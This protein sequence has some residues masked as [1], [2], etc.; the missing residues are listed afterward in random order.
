MFDYSVQN[1]SDMLLGYLDGKKRRM[2]KAK[3]RNKAYRFGLRFGV[4]KYTKY[5]QNIVKEIIA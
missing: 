4:G 5:Q 3:K 1:Y 2:R